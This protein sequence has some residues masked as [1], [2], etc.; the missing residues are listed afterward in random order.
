M[1]LYCQIHMRAQTVFIL[2]LLVNTCGAPPALAEAP[3]AEG[4]PAII[5]MHLHA[6]RME[7]LPPGTPSCPGDQPVLVPTIDPKDDLE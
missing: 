7:E 6:F 1:Q 4:R 3:V 5:D 2:L